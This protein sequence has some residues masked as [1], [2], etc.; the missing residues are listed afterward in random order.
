MRPWL[1]AVRARKGYTQ[2]QVA[3][4]VGISRCFYTQI[5][6]MFENKG[7]S[8]KIAMRI[9]ETLEFDWVWFFQEEKVEMEPITSYNADFFRNGNCG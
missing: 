5:E 4:Q 3:D 6:S 7:L 2:Q 1:K 9:A 8:P